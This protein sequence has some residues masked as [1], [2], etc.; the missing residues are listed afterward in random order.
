MSARTSVAR[1]LAGPE[2]WNRRRLQLLLV[3]AVLVVIAVVAGIVWSVIELLGAGATPHSPS[4]ESG[5]AARDSA[6]A[7]A[8]SIDE[9]RPGPLSTGHTGTIRI[10]QPSKLGGAQVGTGFPPTAEGALAQLIAIDRRAIESASV[11]TAQDVIAVWAAPGGPS[12]ESWSGVAAV[13]TLLEAAGLPANGSTDL[14][15]QLEPAMGLV[16]DAGT[17]MATVCVDFIVTAR[18]VGN[19]PDRVA[20]ADCQHMTWHGDSWAIASGEEA[21]PTPSL[22]PGTQASYDAG[23]RWLEFLP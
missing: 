11:V 13:Q 21:E 15:I 5:T 3:V 18:V 2:E 20:A 12:A 9:A 7:R 22:W 23:Y 1:M 17:G 14:A 4:A 6:A 19:P 10:P 8:T 16:L